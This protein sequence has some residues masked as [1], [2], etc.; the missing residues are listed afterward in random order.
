M[1][2][3]A[4]VFP[5][6]PSPLIFFSF[7]LFLFLFLQGAWGLGVGVSPFFFRFFFSFSFTS[8][9]TKYVE[10]GYAASSHML[11]DCWHR[12]LLYGEKQ[13]I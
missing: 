7:F 10:Y 6:S 11:G 8:L 1:V 13:C 2:D 12:G 3:S 9:L 4:R 5:L